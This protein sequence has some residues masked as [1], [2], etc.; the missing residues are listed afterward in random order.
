MLQ[1]YNTLSRKKEEFKPLKSGKVGMYACGPTVYDIAHIGNLRTYVFIDILKRILQYDGHKVN[2]IMNLTDVDDKTIKAGKGEK[3]K[4]FELTRHFSDLFIADLKK[5]NIEL[6]D[7]FTRATEYIDQMVKFVEDLMKK[8]FAYKASDN[9]IYFSIDKFKDYGKL[10]CLDKEGIKVGARVDSDEYD[11]ENPSDFA[12]W[13]AWDEKDGEIFWETSL[14]K[15]RPGW[16]IECSAMSSTELGDTIDIHAGAVDLVFPHH[17]NEIAQSEA[18][19]GKKFVNYWIHGEHL[20]VENKKMSKSL[21][22]MYNLKDLEQKG[23]SPLDFRFLIL[24][25]HYRMKLN[26]TWA[27]IE[28]AKTARMKLNDFV[29]GIKKTGKIN[30]EF[31]G[32]F[33]ELINDDMAMPQVMALVWE[34]TK[35]DIKDEDKKATLLDFD[36]VLGLGLDKIEAEK[37]PQAVIDSAEQRL[38]A[39]K[40]KDFKKSDELRDEIGKLGF[41]IEDTKEGYKLKRK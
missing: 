12:L 8:G 38:E 11:K 40:A 34:V 6:P 17:E 14:G 2:Y 26:F 18:R 7:K 41:E 28:G 15:G 39:K 31:K 32:K 9:S 22:N 37:V 4:F 21:G 23:F 19:S 20:L 5:L 27:S 3:A 25:S 16:H 36:K 35:S 13:K 33:V 29:S 30:K 1:I 10:S 24:G